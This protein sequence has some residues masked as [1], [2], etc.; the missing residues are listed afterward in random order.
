MEWH[1]PAERDSTRTAVRFPLQLPLH[2]KTEKGMFDAISRDISSNGILFT[3][4]YLPE[5]GS[6]I[7]FSIDMPSQYMGWDHDGSIKCTGRIVRHQHSEEEWMA[8]AVI[9]E[10]FFRA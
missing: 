6:R 1:R 7:E 2:L 5:I 9:D 3:I 10:Y 8:A 4:P